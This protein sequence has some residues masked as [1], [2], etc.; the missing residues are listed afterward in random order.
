MKKS[1]VLL[2]GAAVACMGLFVHKMMKKS[3]YDA[4][5]PNGN[6]VAPVNQAEKPKKQRKSACGQG[7]RT[8]RQRS[9]ACKSCK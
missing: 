5:Y 7:G 1:K 4:V 3:A 9:S 6:A 8:E 2:I